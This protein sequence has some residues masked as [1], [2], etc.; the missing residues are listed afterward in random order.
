[1]DLVGNLPEESYFLTSACGIIV[2]LLLYY[3]NIII[4][5]ANML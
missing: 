4:F 2:S 1:M 3:Y 5:M